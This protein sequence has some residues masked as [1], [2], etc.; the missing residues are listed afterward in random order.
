MTARP[1]G[2]VLKYVRPAV[3]DVERA[4]L[5][6]DQ[7]L[8]DELVAAVDEAGLLGAVLL[9]PLGHGVEFGLVVLAEVGGVGVRDRAA[10]AHPGHR[11]RR[12]EPAGERDA[13][14]FADRQ[15]H[16]HTLAAVL[17]ARVR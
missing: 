2:V 12:V 13:D 11:R 3:R 17:A 8:A 9:G 7:P 14:P 16:Q 15:R 4:A 6:R 10:F 5:Q 1:S